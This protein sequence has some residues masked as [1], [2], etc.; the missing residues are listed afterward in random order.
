MKRSSIALV[1]DARRHHVARDRT[2]LAHV[3]DGDLALRD[4]NADAVLLEQPPDR[5][6]HVR[7]HVVHAFLR[8]GDPEAQL[9]VEAVVVEA[10]HA[11]HRRRIAQDA[12]LTLG[13][14][15]Q[16][17]ERFFRIALVADAHRQ[18]QAHA[19]IGVAPVDDRVRDQVLV[20][21]Q[22]LDAVAIAH[23]DVTAAQLLHPAEPLGAGA[24]RAGEADDVAGLDRAV[25][26]QHEAADEIRRDRLQAEA[27][28]DADRAGEHVQRSEVEARGIEAEQDRQADQERLREL[29]DADAHATAP[30][31]AS[32]S[33]AVRTSARSRSRPA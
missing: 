29:R 27:E 22:R 33:A 30:G 28:A 18:L 7:A 1:G 25:H 14:L 9:Q 10:H 12:R 24:G 5:A 4:R 8:I 15:Q 17:C 2:A 11:R 20:R 32:T 6:V 31:P 23:H 13:R 16:H 21:H 19:R 3:H 26:Q